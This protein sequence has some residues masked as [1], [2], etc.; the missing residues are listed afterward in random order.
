MIFIQSRCFVYLVLSL[1]QKSL[2]TYAVTL[3]INEVAPAIEISTA[4]ASV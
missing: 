4:A 1:E 2:V 3:V